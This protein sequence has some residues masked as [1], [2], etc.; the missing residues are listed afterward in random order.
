MFVTWRSIHRLSDW[1]PLAGMNAVGSDPATLNTPWDMEN[2]AA[3]D[4]DWSEN[5]DSGPLTIPA[6]YGSPDPNW[7]VV[8]GKLPLNP[9]QAL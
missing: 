8:S 6:L 4:P 2:G 9:V 1:L 3:S 5:A 7:L